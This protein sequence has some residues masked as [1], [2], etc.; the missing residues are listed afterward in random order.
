MKRVALRQIVR[1]MNLR[2]LLFA[3][4]LPALLGVSPLA[5]QGGPGTRPFEF[6]TDLSFINQTGN[7]ELTT[8]GFAEKAIF[9]PGWRWTFTQYAGL[10]YG[11][12]S[13]E[14]K[15]ESYQTGL[16]ADFAFSPF[17]GAYGSWGFDRNRFSGLAERYTYSAGMS[18][19]LVD[20]PSD[21]AKVEAGLARTNQL[22]TARLESNFFSARFAGEYRHNFKPTT[23][24]RGALELL[25]NLR[26]AA[27]MRINSLAEVVAPISAHIG[28][29]TKYTVKYDHEPAPTFQDTDTI[30]QTGLQITF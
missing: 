12:N 14:V 16:Q 23:Y 26:D 25:P 15:A 13:G 21:Q 10:I 22:S 29:K 5:G 2:P 28:L 20:I 17:I 8:T 18:A 30:L 9:R 6:S 11:K 4:G 1:P 3:L 24:V 27:D 19:F 7:T